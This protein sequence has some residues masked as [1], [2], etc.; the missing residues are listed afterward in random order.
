MESPDPLT[1][2]QD[3]ITAL[4]SKT[5]LGGCVKVSRTRSDD[6]SPHVE[7]FGDT[8]EIV[9]T[10]RGRETKRIP[11]LSLSDAARWF[12]FGMAVHHAQSSELRDRRTPRD[13]S[14]QAYGLKDIGYSRWN[15]MAPAI[16]LMRQVSPDFGDWAA[17]EYAQ[18]LRDHPLS[19]SEIRN[20]CY[21]IP[22]DHQ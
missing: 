20:A 5:G 3:L 10:E 6:G 22:A 8:Y 17:E 2:L 1:D 16:T 18:T 14:P 13:A 11:A 15:W 12:V 19:E 21:P 4:W 7:H 9:I